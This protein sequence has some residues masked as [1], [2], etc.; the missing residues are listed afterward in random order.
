MSAF[1]F[2]DNLTFKIIWYLIYI[3]NIYQTQDKIVSYTS[4]VNYTVTCRGLSCLSFY[5]RT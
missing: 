1:S 2:C 3:A 5:E 4:W